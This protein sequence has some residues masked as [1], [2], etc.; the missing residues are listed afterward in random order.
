MSDESAGEPMAAG[1]SRDRTRYLL[2]NGDI[3]FLNVAKNL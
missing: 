3:D 1:F 2:W